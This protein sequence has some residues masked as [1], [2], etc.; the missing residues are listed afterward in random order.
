[1]PIAQDGPVPIN[2]GLVAKCPGLGYTFVQKLGRKG[3]QSM[4]IGGIELGIQDVNRLFQEVFTNYP[5]NTVNAAALKFLFLNPYHRA[6]VVDAHGAVQFLDPYSE[7]ALGIKP[8]EAKNM[9]VNELMPHSS[10]P[11]VLETGEPVMARIFDVRGKKLVSAAFPLVVD[12]QMVGAIGRI[13]F[14]SLEE[15]ERAYEEIRRSR[16]L[17]RP[18]NLEWGK[19]YKAKYSFKDILFMSSSM[20]E[21]VETAKK[22]S[23]LRTDVLIVGETGTGKELLAHSIHN[24]LDGD[25][26]FVRVNCA[27]IPSELAESELFGYERG[28]FTGALSSGK[29]GCFEAAGGGTVF[30][31]EI[32]TLPKFIQ[33]KLLR[34]LQEREIVRVGSTKPRRIEF[35][36]IAATNTDLKGLVEKGEFRPDLY[37]RLARTILPVPP[38]RERVEDIPFYANHFLRAINGS[39]GLKVEKISERAM[40]RL[41]EYTWPGNVRELINV[42]EQAVINVW[43]GAEIEE[44]HLPKYLLDFGNKESAFMDGPESDFRSKIKEIEKKLIL[45][46]LKVTSWNRR[47]AAKLLGMP[48]STFYTKLKCYGLT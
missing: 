21:T 20:R 30:L 9:P 33:A 3:G 36:V 38:L 16:P 27:A 25:K 15:F 14:H 31:D 44:K 1:M 34:T 43:D 7:M 46:A 42:I 48:K 8:G 18:T 11:R 39:F 45:E 37:Y 12:H 35:R 41:M 6:L 22:L 28:S 17:I 23:K 10:L 29:T 19:E 32:S 47:K 40:G 26:P 5:L 4:L 24:E 2:K 13:L